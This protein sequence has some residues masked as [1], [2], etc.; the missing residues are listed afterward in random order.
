MRPRLRA[1]H[2]GFCSKSRH[3][4]TCYRLDTVAIDPQRTFDL[5]TC[6]A[7]LFRVSQ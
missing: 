1:G 5:K 6:D 3:G 2:F 7:Y 4:W